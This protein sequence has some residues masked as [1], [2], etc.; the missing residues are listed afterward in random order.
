[1]TKQKPRRLQAIAYDKTSYGAILEATT[2]KA[3]K[4]ELEEG[5]PF[6]DA[7]EEIEENLYKEIR[8][9]DTGEILWTD[10]EARHLE[11]DGD[12][13]DY[14]LVKRNCWISVERNGKAID[15]QIFQHPHYV[16]VTT[17]DATDEV[18]EDS[19]TLLKFSIWDDAL[20]T[21][22]EDK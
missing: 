22:K 13:A 17:W 8:D 7:N 2:L 21:K 9:A 6:F 5:D 11:E 4:K 19:N 20:N 15:I 12:P 3:A 18:R 1:M 14:K 10:K 16:T